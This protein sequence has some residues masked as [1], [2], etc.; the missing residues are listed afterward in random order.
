LKPLQ[1]TANQRHL[2]H[3]W[4][5]P[6]HI[7]ALLP[8]ITYDYLRKLCKNGLVHKIHLGDGGHGYYVLSEVGKVLE[9]PIDQPIARQPVPEVPCPALL[10][11]RDIRN[12]IGFS[13]DYV[14]RLVKA[15]ALKPFFKHNRAKALY[16]TWQVVHLLPPF[17]LVIQTEPAARRL[18]RRNVTKWLGVTA[19]EL[20]SWVRLDRIHRVLGYYDKNEIQREILGVS[21]VAIKTKRIKNAEVGPKLGM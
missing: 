9:L 8:D 18:R 16:P 10:R 19:A 5:R 17:N 7:R 15:R 13:R 14:E 11:L 2:P 1:N 3:A 21:G 12:R 20:E 6:R 4:L